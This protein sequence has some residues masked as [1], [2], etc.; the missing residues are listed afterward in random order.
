MQVEPQLIPALVL[1]TYRLRP[2]VFTVS[3]NVR[4]RP[5][6]LKVAVTVVFEFSVIVAL[7][8]PEVPPPLNLRIRSRPTAWRQ[9]DDSPFEKDLEQ[10]EPQSI[11]AGVSSRFR[12][13][14]RTSYLS[15][16]DRP[17]ASLRGPLSTCWFSGCGRQVIA[18]ASRCE[19]QK[20]GEP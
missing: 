12:F 8:V 11:P 19:K 18:P 9:G 7:P 16:T 4:R 17:R 13:Q 15:V 3:V 14:C 20:N 5:E 1:V 6:A 10:V 2:S